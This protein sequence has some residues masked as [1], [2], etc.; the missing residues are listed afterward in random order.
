M[1]DVSGT[2]NSKSLATEAVFSKDG[3]V[4][5]RINN[6]ESTV[7][8]TSSDNVLVFPP[9][10]SN[11]K[12]F[13]IPVVLDAVHDIQAEPA[14]LQKSPTRHGATLTGF[15]IALTFS[16]S[17]YSIFFS[18]QPEIVDSTSNNPREGAAALAGYESNKLINLKRAADILL[19]D[20]NWRTSDINRFLDQWNF[21]S[22][23]EVQSV[24]V[25]AWYQLFAFNVKKHITQQQK[26]QASSTASANI[27]QSLLTL[28]LV[29]GVMNQ[30]NTENVATSDSANAST[31]GK[32]KYKQLLAELTS[33]LKQAENLSK[34]ADNEQQNESDLN[35]RMK[36]KYAFKQVSQGSS[37]LV[38]PSINQNDIKNITD[39]YQQAYVKGDMKLM[40][41]LFGAK[42]TKS[43]SY[44]QLST[45]FNTTFRNTI[46]R[47]MS[48]YDHNMELSGNSAIIK[49]ML[50][51]SVEFKNGKGKQFT[52]A[53]IIMNLQ[54]VNG[55]LII[56]R[57]NVLNRKV[58]VVSNE[59]ANISETSSKADEIVTFPTAAELQDITTQL[60]TS[61]ETGDLKQFVSLL[62]KEI[63]TNDRIDLAGVTSDY[64]ELFS[65]TSD[66]QMFIQNLIWNNEKIG[67]K[68]TG[69]L[70]VVILSDDGNPVYSMEGKIQIVAQKID[71][72]V[73]ITHLYH[74]ER[75]K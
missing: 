59:R 24:V 10:Q 6:Y 34:R 36:E 42:N 39:N 53:E 11:N 40:A 63:K 7:V 67:A 47:S 1:G 23:E 56:S 68:G 60:V 75:E 5:K 54:I 72:N 3:Q 43:E 29:M 4:K 74:I 9:Q 26:L 22:E 37:K 62:S 66:R 17:I 21:L 48:F 44:K 65:T 50:N 12:E 30:D 32:S 16:W 33:E 58:N 15:I 55:E 8:E 18:V 28:G 64:S 45:N 38:S 35:A 51:S 31:T 27:S 20:S 14:V 73:K 49:S 69:D 25:T 71:H 46:N 19:D 57:F 41:K 13:D 2:G 52:V 70:E 61:Y